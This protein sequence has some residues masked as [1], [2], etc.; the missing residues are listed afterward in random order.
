LQWRPL[1]QARPLCRQ[2]R[3]VVHG[4]LDIGFGHQDIP[5]T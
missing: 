1:L 5:D 2:I 3:V 4:I